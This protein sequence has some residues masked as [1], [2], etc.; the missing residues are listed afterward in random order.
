MKLKNLLILT[1]LVL[2]LIPTVIVSLLLYQSGF[3][4]SRQSSLRNLTEST[5]VQVDYIVQTIEN[6]LV[7]DRRFL[8]RNFEALSHPEDTQALSQV[9]RTYLEASDDKVSTCVLLDK[10]GKPAFTLGEKTEL[11]QILPK[12]AN[13][14]PPTQQ[15]VQEFQLSE[16]S[17]SLGL[18]TPLTDQKGTYYGALISVYQESYLL[19]I[20]SSYY[21]VS[22]TSMFIF[23]QDGSIVNA[24]TNTSQENKDALSQSLGALTFEEE[25]IVELPMGNQRV[26]GYYKNIT[27]CPWL[28]ISLIHNNTI[29]DFA[30]QFIP[31]YLLVIAGVFLADLLLSVYFSNKVVKPINALIAVMER[32]HNQLDINQLEEQDNGGYV[33]TKYLHTRFFSLMR[34]ILRVQHNFSGVYQ[35]YR[36]G[37]AGDINIDIDTKAQ[38]VQCDKEG[39]QQLIESVVLPPDKCVVERFT[40]CFCDKDQ[41][42]LMGIFEKMRDEHLSVTAEAELF[43]PQLGGKWYHALVV[44]M[45]EDE[46]LSQLMIQLRDITAFRQQE[47]QSYQQARKDPLTGL[48]NR[49]GFTDYGDKVLENTQETHALLFLDMD[50]FKLVNDTLGHRAGDELLREVGKILTET[51]DPG[52]ICARLGGDEF[53]VLLPS[54]TLAQAQARQQVLEEMLSFPFQTPQRSFTVSASIGLAL[55]QPTATLS[56]LLQTADEA[57]YQVKRKKKGGR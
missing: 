31:L 17:Y 29:Y 15:G 28:L 30:N 6:G 35:L 4:L 32:Y 13:F 37:G 19:K 34:T 25:G 5:N 11:D 51:A 36:S 43:T 40:H 16:T 10:E 38:T 46:R 9:F 41:K 48:Y 55:S 57:M 1:F 12:L 53:A 8:L 21:N 18:V 47:L 49:T 56:M 50:Y 54:I 3:E 23:R 2:T 27:S 44:P 20:I 22:N 52:D 39:F 33:E 45:Y 26:S 7:G 42:M 14:T 24:K